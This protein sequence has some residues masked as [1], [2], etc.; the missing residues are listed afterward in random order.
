MKVADPNF[1]ILNKIKRLIDFI[2]IKQHSHKTKAKKL[3]IKN[4][5]QNHRNIRRVKL[6]KLKRIS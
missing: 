5:N 6:N 2:K 1:K 3:K 4:F